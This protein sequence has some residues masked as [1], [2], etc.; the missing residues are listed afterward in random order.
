[1]GMTQAALA[2]RVGISGSYL[3]LIE[4]G[5]REVG[6]ALL[7]RLAGALDLDRAALTGAEDTRLVQDLTGLSADPALRDLGLDPDGAQE[8][9]GRQPS[10][11]R[12]LLRLH[13]SYR[14]ASELV[15][16]L[17]DRLS[18]DAFL[19]QSSHELLTRIT[20]VR[21]F[22]E[23]LLEH[24]D[25]ATD[26]RDRFTALLAEESRRLT[27]VAKS[28]FD[29]LNGLGATPR[30]TSPAEEVDDFLI[31]NRNHFPSLEDAAERLWRLVQAGGDTA[32]SA[33]VNR[34]A[35]RH[36]VRMRFGGGPDAAPGQR[37]QVRYDAESR[38][39][40]IDEALPPP[41]LRFELARVLFR[42]ESPE[43]AEA[44]V[45]DPHLTSDEARERARQALWSYAAA[46]MLF[47]YD[48]FLAAARDV[49]YDLE[50]LC[51][52]FGGSIEQICHR[53]VALRRPGAEGV[54]FAFLRV[55]PAGN[56]SKRFS[57]PGLRLPRQGGACPLWAVYRAFMTPQSIVAQKVQLPGGQEFLFIART[58]S[59]QTAAYGVPAETY[60]VMI[61]C[62]ALYADQVVYGDSFPA[63][64]PSLVTGVGVN[65]RLCPRADCRQR[66]HPPI[67]PAAS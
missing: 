42:L 50:V 4:H 17:S 26:R 19:L 5:K 64:R 35:G 15:D 57:L 66:A 20:S 39:L 36:G 14:D 65:C 49:R 47:P 10:W 56:I 62:E 27:T 45:D 34:L 58:V 46:A 6:G 55:D 61:G 1:M 28:L 8:I 11:G 33:L 52:Q 25:L 63:R 41:T 53:L 9:V 60:A 2:Q 13:R 54:P 48:E 44:L 23:I 51:R 37:Q 40:H 3:N 29:H 43:V 24:R 7:K 67:L 18:E 32:E 38:L 12:A 21:S 30:P 16:A 22:A 59:K 31:D